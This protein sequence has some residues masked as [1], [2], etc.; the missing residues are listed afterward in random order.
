MADLT[1]YMGCLRALSEQTDTL[2]RAAETEDW[3]S[4]LSGLD[5]RQNLIEQIDQMPEETRKMTGGDRA[6]ALRILES[7]VERDREITQMITAAISSTRIAMDD[8]HLAQTTLN[9]YRRTSAAQPAAVAAGA[10]FV[11]KQ[12]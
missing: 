5:L 11:D 2:R 7:L 12:R 8:L 4:L 10:R 6:E 1:T 3:D 9:A